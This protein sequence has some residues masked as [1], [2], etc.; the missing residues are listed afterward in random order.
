MFDKS[1]DIVT[2]LW[3]HQLPG[4]RASG[5][6]HHGHCRHRCLLLTGRIQR[7]AVAAVAGVCSGWSTVLLGACRGSAGLFAALQP[8]QDRCGSR[9]RCGS[10]HHYNQGRTRPAGLLH[11]GRLVA[12]RCHQIQKTD[13]RPGPPGPRPLPIQGD[14]SMSPMEPVITGKERQRLS[15]GCAWSQLKKRIHATTEAA[16]QAQM[17]GLK[18]VERRALRQALITLRSHNRLGS[19]HG[20]AMLCEYNK[21]IQTRRAP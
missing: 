3:P 12:G 18:P 15:R 19:S 10:F 16:V 2:D 21:T 17:P 11:S 8:A 6:H 14:I 4:R 20:A 7:P 9:A 1:K 13:P 5:Q